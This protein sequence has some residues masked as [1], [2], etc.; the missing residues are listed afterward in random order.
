M[1]MLCD[2]HN[3]QMLIKLTNLRRNV[4]MQI[5]ELKILITNVME[6]FSNQQQLS[7]PIILF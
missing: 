5:V 3:Q 2:G 4:L 1:F 7:E 6:K